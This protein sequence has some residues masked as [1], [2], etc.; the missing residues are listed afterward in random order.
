MQNRISSLQI[1]PRDFF[2]VVV[3]ERGKDDVLGQG[4]V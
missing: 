4:C 2:V 1:L 3:G